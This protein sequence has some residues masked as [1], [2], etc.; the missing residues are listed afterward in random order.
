MC[1]W[2]LLILSGRVQVDPEKFDRAYLQDN[3]PCLSVA[4]GLAL[5][6]FD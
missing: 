2:K 4:M 3:A 1:R 6:S 5:R